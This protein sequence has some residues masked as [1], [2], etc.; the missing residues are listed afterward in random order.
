[1]LT[2]GEFVVRKSAVK[3]IGEGYLNSVNRYASGGR[4]VKSRSGYGPRDIFRGAK[5]QRGALQQEMGG[6]QAT[7]GK[8]VDFIIE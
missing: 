2:P 5:R 6:L 4:V 7:T 8:N 3:Q 1:M